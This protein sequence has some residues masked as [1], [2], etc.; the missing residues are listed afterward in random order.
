[1]NKKIIL[2]VLSCLFSI[3][4]ACTSAIISGSVTED[5]RPLLWKHR[6]TGSLENQ[7]LYIESEPFNFI[8]V[9][10]AEDLLA[11][12]V[13]M[14]VND[15]GFSIMNTASYNINTDTTCLVED[16]QE[17]EFMRLALEKCASV[18]DFEALLKN[19]SGKWGIAAN[20]GVIDALG[21]AAYFEAGYYTYTKYDANDPTTAPQGYLVRTNFSLSGDDENGQGYLRYVE[22]NK[23][24]SQQTSFNEEFLSRKMSR[25]LGHAAV[26][27]DLE[28]AK[29][30][31]CFKDTTLMPFQD[32]IARYW[33]ASD[34]IVKGAAKGQDPDET[35]LY[36]IM[37]FSL[38]TLVTP[39]YYSFREYLPGIVQNRDGMAPELA[40]ASLALKARCFPLK[41]D[42]H[43]N[44]IDLSRLK[45]K[46]RVGYLD[47]I[48]SFEDRIMKQFSSM[49][50]DSGQEEIEKYT[51]WLD[52]YI[53]GYYKGYN[54]SY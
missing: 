46:F 44:Y 8:G 16:D 32:Y 18:D 50:P 25:H 51:N 39:V 22:A 24:F 6:D 26:K 52:N 21:N 11:K 31:K 42:D 14:G 47:K 12:S 45:N 40:R 19:E 37:G 43:E 9:V 10:N 33:S 35:V 1:M 4:F 20:F 41:H 2:I 53:M 29:R 27:N 5:G 30:P 34:L 13:W 17:G 7:L 38:T 49:S 3:S 48:G 15:A 54:I 28:S 36:P 23:V